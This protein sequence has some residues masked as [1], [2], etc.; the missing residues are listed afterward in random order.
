MFFVHGGSFH[1]GSSRDF[2]PKYLL[3]SN[4]TLVIPEFR[5][6]ALGFLS[7]QTRDIPGN[8]GLMDVIAALEFVQKHIPKFGGDPSRVT[9]VGQS[10]G[11]V[12]VSQLGISPTVPKNLFNRMIV[13]SGSIY[14]AWS[15][16]LNPVENARDIGERAG[17]SSRWSIYQLNRAFMAMDAFQLLNATEYH[18]VSTS[19]VAFDENKYLTND[20]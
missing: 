20:E 2:S 3:E 7:T 16:A 11:G 18:N 19:L 14:S 13:Q 5:L 6:D 17:I 12:M 15:Y 1:L 4:I 8:A 9:L 10:S